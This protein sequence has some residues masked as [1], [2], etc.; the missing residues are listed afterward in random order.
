MTLYEYNVDGP[1]GRQY[2]KDIKLANEYAQKIA[3]ETHASVKRCDVY[4]GA[5]IFSPRPT[6]Y[7]ARQQ[8]GGT[9]GTLDNI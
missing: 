2:F 1:N 6:N 7:L 9:V 5:S 4:G 8:R 3:N